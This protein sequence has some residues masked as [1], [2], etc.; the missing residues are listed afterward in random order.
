M[1]NLNGNNYYM[2]TLKDNINFFFVI[3]RKLIYHLINYNIQGLL[4]K[5]II[6]FL[7]SLYCKHYSSIY[8]NLKKTAMLIEQE[9]EKIPFLI[10]FK[11]C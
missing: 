2:K 7:N 4:Q 9:L 3:K 10:K 11:Y 1:Q 6:Y 5:E 8:I